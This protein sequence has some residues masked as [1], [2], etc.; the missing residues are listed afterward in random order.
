MDLAVQQ[1][2]KSASTRVALRELK[3]QIFFDQET[4]GTYACD[5]NK[6][7]FLHFDSNAFRVLQETKSDTQQPIIQS[8]ASHCTTFYHSKRCAH[9]NSF[10][11]AR[12]AMFFPIDCFA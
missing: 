10:D 11:C 1:T 6:N 2:K 12:F 5:M 7:R 3:P 8:S 9:C 4:L